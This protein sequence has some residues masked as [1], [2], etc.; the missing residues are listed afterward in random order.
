MPHRIATLAVED[1]HQQDGDFI[2]DA[3]HV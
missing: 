3:S 1:D 2:F